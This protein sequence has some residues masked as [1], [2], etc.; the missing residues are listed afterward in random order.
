MKNIKFNRKLAVLA[1]ATTL[2]TTSLSGCVSYKTIDNTITDED[3]L[4]DG[5]ILEDTYVMTLNNGKKD[6]VRKITPCANNMH[7]IFYSVISGQYIVSALCMD[8]QLIIKNGDERSHKMLNKSNYEE[9]VSITEYLSME[10]LEKAYKKELTDDDIIA[11][12]SRIIEPEEPKKD[13]SKIKTKIVNS[14][15]PLVF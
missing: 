7:T 5:T 11:I 12:I 6:I 13:E 10:D 15:N 8:D 4:L 3:N 14:N 2:A 9:L 1:L